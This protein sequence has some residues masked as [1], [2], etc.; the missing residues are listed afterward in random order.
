M[1]HILEEIVCSDCGYDNFM[2]S[3]EHIKEMDLDLV[4]VRGI[5]KQTYETKDLIIIECK[6]ENCRHR[7]CGTTDEVFIKF[8]GGND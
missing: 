2:V 7:R 8:G 5:L 6:T 3:I 1:K 4:R